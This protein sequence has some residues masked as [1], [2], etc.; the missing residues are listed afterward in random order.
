[1]A[2]RQPLSPGFTNELN[3]VA[4]LSPCNAW[5]VGF[6]GD[7]NHG[8]TLIEH[9]DGAAWTVVPSPSP[10][11]EDELNGV[12]A[13]SSHDIWAV[14]ESEGKT[15][16]ERYDGSSWTVVPSP[17]PSPSTDPTIFDTLSSVHAVSANDVWAAGFLHHRPP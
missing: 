6:S 4:V 7:D 5:A 15:L 1:M 2:A 11:N 14:G 8:K 9:W 10:G 17:S 16:T 13:L 12:R 3:A